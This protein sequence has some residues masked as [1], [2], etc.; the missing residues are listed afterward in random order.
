MLPRLSGGRRGASDVHDVT[1][2]LV[3]EA[4]MRVDEDFA[5]VEFQVL[6]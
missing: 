4:G 3:D 5:F 6:P 2:V 1:V